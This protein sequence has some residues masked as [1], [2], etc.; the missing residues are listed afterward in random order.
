MIPENVQ[1]LMAT[2]DF[3]VL[4]MGN[5]FFDITLVRCDDGREGTLPAHGRPVEPLV[6]FAV[7]DGR[8]VSA[9]FQPNIDRRIVELA[10]GAY[11]RYIASVT[12]E[13]HEA[14]PRLDMRGESDT[15]WL[16]Q[17]WSLPDT[18]A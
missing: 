12:E 15:D 1:R 11:E 7:V 14:A 3:P 10:A 6:A 16:E 13:S 9:L 8:P 5:E 18:R 2:G 4:V 17:L